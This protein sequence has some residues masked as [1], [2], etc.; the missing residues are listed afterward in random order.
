MNNDLVKKNW[1]I[2]C[3]FLRIL[4]SVFSCCLVNVHFG[5]ESLGDF[6]IL[7]FEGGS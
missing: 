1:S 3:L 6:E 5:V 4:Q 7:D 2:N